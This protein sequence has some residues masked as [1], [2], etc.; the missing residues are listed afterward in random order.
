MPDSNHKAT[1][2]LRG[3]S[4]MCLATILFAVSNAIAKWEVALYPAGEVL[5]WRSL[6]TFAV[7]FAC[8]APLGG[9]LAS[10]RTTKPLSHLARGGSQAISQG[11]TVLALSLMPLAGAAAFSF[12]APL[13]AALISY[14]VLR[15]RVT[16]ARGLALSVGFAGVLVVAQP[17]AGLPLLGIAFAL[18]NAIMYGS[19]TVAVRGMAKTET[20]NCLLVWQVTLLALAHAALLPLGYRNPVPVDL[21]LLALCGLANAGAQ[22]CWTRALVQAPT[23]AVGPFYYLLLV[24]SAIAGFLVWGDMPTWSVLLGAL[25]IAAASVALV[26]QESRSMAAS[27]DEAAARAGANKENAVSR[28]TAGLMTNPCI[29][30]QPSARSIS[31]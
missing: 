17:S 11:L 23:A 9:G 12:S 13:W 2:V 7:V 19:V 28:G 1:S 31:S 21:L 15:E 5:F 20:A 16:M 3:I 27:A 29:S 22:Y 30:S 14:F 8:V 24:W 18:G 26:W 6:F 10:Y 25:V 4:F